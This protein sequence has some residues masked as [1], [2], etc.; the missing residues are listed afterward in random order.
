MDR[1]EGIYKVKKVLFILAA[2]LMTANLDAQQ[3]PIYSQ[4]IFNK[5]LINPAVAGSDGYTS[6]NLTTRQQWTGY[7][8]APQTYSLSFNG[9]LLK[10]KY[11]IRQNL[12]DKKIFKPH[13]EGK[14]GLGATIYSDINGLVRRTGFSTLLCISPVASG[15]DSAFVRSRFYGLSLQ[16]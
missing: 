15:W 10:Q 11:L 9:R 3:L 7:Q 14:V 1:C 4:Y 12:F 16:D 6:I 5:Y 13:T 8:G 2:V